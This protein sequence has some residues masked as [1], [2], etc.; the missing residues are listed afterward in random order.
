MSKFKIGD[1]VY[2]EDWCYGQI[3]DLHSSWAV[4]EYS[5]PAG[6][7]S[8]SFKLSELYKAEPPKSYSIRDNLLITAGARAAYMDMRGNIDLPGGLEGEDRLAEFVVDAV[9]TYSKITDDIPFDEFIERELV[10]EFGKVK[11]N[12]QLWKG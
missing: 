4:V 6:G 1:W 10:C 7:G 2:A 12:N 5:T 9:R 3:V 8:F 11:K